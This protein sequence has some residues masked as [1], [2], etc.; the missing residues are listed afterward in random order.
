MITDSINAY[1]KSA[2]E[3]LQIR[4]ASTIGVRI[5]NQWAKSLTPSSKVI[6]IACGGGFPVTKALV[7]AGLQ[8]WAIDPSPTL[9]AT[10]KERFPE[11]PVQCAAILES[12]YFERQ[13]DA[14]ISIG[15]IFLLNEDDQVKMLSRVAELLFTGGRFLFTAPIE[16]GAWTDVNT[17]HACTSLG[18]HRYEREL[19]QSGFR[20]V[21]RYEDSGKN[22]YYDAEK[23]A[24]S[25][26]RN[27]A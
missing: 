13:F 22:N 16:E 17:G 3:F 26:P 9:L 12:D 6:E 11:I 23:I 14:A 18:Q 1:E 10:F 19:K 4:D 25:V 5:T 27:A 15:L 20:V 21:N 2:R 24:D 7:G 8:V